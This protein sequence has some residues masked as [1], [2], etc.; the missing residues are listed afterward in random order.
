MPLNLFAI[1][2]NLPML[3]PLI[4]KGV[5]TDSP[6]ITFNAVAVASAAVALALML[7]PTDAL[8]Q[9]AVP[10]AIGATSQ[11][12]ITG[13]EVNGDNPLTPSDSARVLAPF[14]VPA[15]TLVTV[16]QA[17]AA[18]DAELKRQ[19]FSMHRVT[20]PAQE[21]G[22]KVTLFV[23]KFV[24]GKVTVEGL[25]RYSEANIRASVP[26]LREGEAPNFQA[27]TVQTTIA[28][29]NAGKQ[30]QATFKEADEADKINATLL[31]KEAAPW[32]FSAGLS[33]TGS[34]ATGRDR[35]SLVGSH[36]NVFNLDHQ[37]SGAYTTSL[38][39]NQAVNQ[40]GLNY[41]VPLYSLGG[42]VGVSYTT[43]KVVGNFGT[44]NSTGAGRTFGVNYTQYLPPDN[45]RRSYL[46][47]GLDSK[48]FNVTQIN[49]LVVPGQLDRATRPITLG[50]N[51]RTEADKE[52]WGYNTELA[53][54][55]PGG[56]SNDLTSYLSEDP[57]IS[58]AS[59]KA[60][61]G[62]ANYFKSYA[63]GWLWSIRGTAQYSGNALISGEQFGLGGASSI[64]GTGERALSGDSG[65]FISTE[66]SSYEL[67]PGLRALAF[68]DVGLLRN[69]NSAVNPNK[70]AKDQL[71]GAG[72]G[73]RYATAG[74]SLALDWG[75][76][77]KGSVL[78]APLG[79]GI[80][81]TGDK[82]LHAS[83]TA[84]F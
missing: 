77:V 8:A 27:L 64:R 43:S 46:S 9:Q 50:Y 82:K 84:R 37:F 18:L 57:R 74:F 15:G 6:N 60:V 17:S 58:T 38:Q 44:F 66:S 29:E 76:I 14:V 22:S 65:L 34:A 41:R 1:M 26:E 48:L 7:A 59:W 24:I 81:Q 28:N 52:V 79:S 83:I 80:P 69:H 61:R 10:P 31:V 62:G 23:V 71:A 42:V 36:A 67:S 4:P 25:S 12:P 72:L 13:F 53:L 20:L 68:L 35:L 54:N 40:L 2:P 56:K 47:V 51:V 30:L 21:M 55:L 32:A 33:N 70:P 75:R 49:G 73:L 11:F 78:P 5:Q 19:G 3:P 45:G 16:Q 63:S 39:R